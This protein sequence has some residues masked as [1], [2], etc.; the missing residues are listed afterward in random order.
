MSGAW[1]QFLLR[2]PRAAPRILMKPPDDHIMAVHLLLLPIHQRP[3]RQTSSE[4]ARWDRIGGKSAMESRALLCLSVRELLSS[5]RVASRR[6][7]QIWC[8]LAEGWGSGQ[9]LWPPAEAHGAVVCAQMNL[10]WSA[11][12][13]VWLGAVSSS[14][15]G[16]APRHRALWV[17]DYGAAARSAVDDGTSLPLQRSTPS[18]PSITRA[19]G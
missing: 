18:T 12:L 7:S 3:D 5:P 8:F 17:W 19:P 13:A 10:T 15:A 1:L 2:R 6:P 11:G 4:Q 14:V 9:G 16:A